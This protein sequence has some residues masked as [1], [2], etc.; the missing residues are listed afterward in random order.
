MRLRE[1]CR[2]LVC[3]QDLLMHLLL[4]SSWMPHIAFPYQPCLL[5]KHRSMYFNSQPGWH[6]CC[7]KPSAVDLSVITALADLTARTNSFSGA[8]KLLVN[9]S[10]CFC[11]TRARAGDPHLANLYTTT[12]CTSGAFQFRLVFK[13]T[14]I[15]GLSAAKGFDS[16]VITAVC[17]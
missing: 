3:W 13:L 5:H 10:D 7:S 2:G 14:L 15:C 11:K 1:K 16:E 6:T 8:S 9:C 17:G 12:W 4:L